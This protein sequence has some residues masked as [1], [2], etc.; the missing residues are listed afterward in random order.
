MIR[1]GDLPQT[2]IMLL[3]FG[4]PR[5]LDEVALFMEQLT[6]KKP[7]SEQIEGLQRRYQAIGGASPLPETTMRQ[8][9]ALEKALKRKGKPLPVFVGMRYS[10]PLIAETLEEIRKLGISRIILISLSPYRTAFSSEGYYDEV[11]RIVASWDEGMELVEVDD[12]HALPSLCAAW[13]AKI[14]EAIGRMG[15]KKDEIPVVFTAHSLPQEVAAGF[16]YVRQV[17]ETI[18]GIIR[19]TGPVRW[20]LAFQSRGR[21]GDEWLGP[22]PE[23]ILADLSQKGYSRVLICPIGFIADHLET[24]YDLDIVLK[25][26]ADKQGIEIT[27]AAC[28]ND[29]PELIEV[30]LQLAEGALEG[31]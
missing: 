5:S 2:A 24:L 4:G 26:W 3:A 1:E 18:K 16:P 27:R 28:L 14:A 10:H 19:F 21:G 20:R 17:E 30:L 23:K 7:S 31:K 15:A 8:A 6:G 11:K 29:A 9:R 12:W 13:A 22:E 25:A